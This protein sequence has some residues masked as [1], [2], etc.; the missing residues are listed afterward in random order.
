MY[1]LDA[2]VF[3]SAKNAHYGMDFA[4]GSGVG[5]TRRMPLGSC[6]PLTLCATN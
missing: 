6:A 5:C 2:N 1:V 3:I 4:Q